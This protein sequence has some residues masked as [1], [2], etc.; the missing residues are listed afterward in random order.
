MVKEWKAEK[1][2]KL[3]EVEI[4]RGKKYLSKPRN[5]IV[6]L[7]IKTL[8]AEHHSHHKV[9]DGSGYEAGRGSAPSLQVHNS[10]QR[11][12]EES[13]ERNGEEPKKCGLEKNSQETTAIF[14]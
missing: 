12:G 6:V 11:Q 2:L 7:S 3:K 5:D 1:R 10:Y 14:I 4:K 8:Q 9:G 13:E